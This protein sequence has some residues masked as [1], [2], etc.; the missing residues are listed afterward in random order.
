[1][2][3]HRR[4]SGSPRLDDGISLVEVMV[5]MVLFMIGSLSLL[6][7]LVSTM[8]GSFDNR[9]RVTAANVAAADIDDARDADYFSLITLPTRD[10]IV[11][12]RT[13]RVTREVQTTMPTGASSACLGSGSSRQYYKRVSTKVE[14]AFKGATAKPVRADTIVRAPLYDPSSTLGAIGFRVMNRDGTPLS[15]LPV[16]ASSL[17]RTTDT[18]GC[19]F[20]DA[21]TPGTV[22]VTVTRPG[23]V[24]RAGSSTLSKNVIVTAGQI[25]TDSLR[26]DTAVTITVSTMA[27]NGSTAWTGQAAP[28]GSVVTI[29][30]SDRSNVARVTYPTKPV[31]LGADTTWTA[32]PSRGGYDAWLGTCLVLDH[33]DSEPGT[34][35]PRIVLPL[36]PVKVRLDGAN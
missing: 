14:T 11:D 1:M 31:T 3:R 8:S 9:A 23:S 6:S 28:S 12:G 26:V 36:S 24:T 25:T 5:A 27:Y 4:G 35:P 13:Y 18:S 21:L 15:G 16:S 34:S 30:A 19:A 32:F 17:N 33:T 29:A 20:F 22:T 10:E 2:H 7:V